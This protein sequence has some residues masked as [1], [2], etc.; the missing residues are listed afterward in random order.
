MKT[1]KVNAY[2]MH[3]FGKI[4]LLSIRATYNYFEMHYFNDFKEAKT[5][6]S[7][8]SVLQAKCIGRSSSNCHE[9]LF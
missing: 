6:I 8:R 4:E 7:F 9:N 1:A 2:I 3:I 5:Y